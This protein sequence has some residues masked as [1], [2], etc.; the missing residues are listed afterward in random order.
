MALDLSALS[1]EQRA[2]VQARGRFVLV[3][4]GPGAGKTTVLTCRIAWLIDQGLARPGEVVALT[5]SQRAG[6]E[7]RQRLVGILGAAADELF[8]GTLH[9][10]AMHLLGQHG[11]R[12]GFRRF[13]QIFASELDRKGVLARAL[14]WL[15]RRAGEDEL[16]PLL[17]RIVQEKRAFRTP[18]EVAAR[19]PELGA[20]YEA[21]QEALRQVP[22]VDFEDMLLHA[23]TLLQAHP[24]AAAAIRAGARYVLVDEVQDLDA[25]QWRF[26]GLL[27]GEGGEL[28]AVG[29]PLQNIYSWRGSDPALLAAC[30]AAP[31]TVQHVLRTNHRSTRTIVRAA[32]AVAARLPLLHE[33]Q[34]PLPRDGPRITVVAVRDPEEEAAFVAGEAWRLVREGAV[35]NWSDI[36]VLYRTR[37]QSRE[38]EAV[39]LE[40]RIPYRVRGEWDLLSTPEVRD[41]LAYLRLAADPGDGYALGRALESA[42]FGLEELARALRYGEPFSLADLRLGRLPPEARVRREDLERFLRFTEELE[43]RARA[44]EP[45]QRLLQAAVHLSG[46]RER[47]GE[48]N[49]GRGR[50]ALEALLLYAARSPS[51]NLARFLQELALLGDD[52]ERGQETGLTLSTVHGAKGLEWRAVFLVGLTEGVLP[53]LR[54]TGEGEEPQEELRLFYVGLTRARDRLYLVRPRYRLRHERPVPQEPSRFLGYLPDDLIE[55]RAIV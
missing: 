17:D 41:V 34:V 31:G 8:A 14:W 11:K 9:A 53:H 38:L 2:A 27:L 51:A 15:G 50:Q 52:L 4:A 42:P 43:V 22:A 5:F 25:V 36:A 37:R 6:A 10:F 44:G 3:R 45:A 12:L 26:L 24:E 46:I 47:A 40:A 29:D 28:F 39:C 33:P 32:E 1:P 48:T 54:S 55:R 16:G 35:R 23:V 13:P 7:L 49:G 20:V 21:Y 19:D 30:A 18:A